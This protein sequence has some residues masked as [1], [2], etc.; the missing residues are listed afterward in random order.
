MPNAWES[1]CKD[2]AEALRK[3]CAEALPG[4]EL[5]VE[6]RSVSMLAQEDDPNV[7]PFY[8]IGAI[9][10]FHVQERRTRY[11]F[12]WRR[13][14]WRRWATLVSF[15]M[16]D[17]WEAPGWASREGIR[18]YA[19]DA[20]VAETVTPIVERFAREHGLLL[21]ATWSQKDP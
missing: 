17:M 13:L 16:E 6:D 2:L 19:P 5:R 8:P 9:F 11:L 10:R 3:A 15:H 21:R 7:V 4:A 18:C 1:R 12:G 20:R 14:P